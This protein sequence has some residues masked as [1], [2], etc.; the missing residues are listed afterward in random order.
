MDD[1]FKPALYPIGEQQI[2][3][4][5]NLHISQKITVQCHVQLYSGNWDARFQYFQE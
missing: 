2:D 4:L 3:A 1:L 5:A